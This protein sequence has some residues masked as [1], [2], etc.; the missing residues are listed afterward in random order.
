MVLC[1]IVYKLVILSP[2]YEPTQTNKIQKSQIPAFVTPPPYRMCPICPAQLKRSHGQSDL[3]GEMEAYIILYGYAGTCAGTA[4]K[5]I[6]FSMRVGCCWAAVIALECSEKCRL[7]S[8]Q[9]FSN[10]L[11]SHGFSKQTKNYSFLSL[12]LTLNFQSDLILLTF[13]PTRI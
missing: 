1:I 12:N 10:T 3:M 11:W 4:E 7:W 8:A 13:D 2:I 9:T 5:V 6:K